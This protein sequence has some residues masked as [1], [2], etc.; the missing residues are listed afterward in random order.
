MES[1]VNYTAVGLFVVIL[2]AA[3]IGLGLWIGADISPKDY[4]RYDAFFNESVS[5]LNANAP[6]K[7]R[8]VTV[9][10]V[11]HI[12]LSPDNPQQV[13]VEMEIEA[14]IPITVATYA[15]LS[16]QGITGIAH[17]ELEGGD[18]LAAA[19]HAHE[20]QH[21]PII[22]TKPSL[23]TRID[24]AVSEVYSTLGVLSEDINMLLSDENRES[25]RMTLRNVAALTEVF[26][27]KST[28]LEKTFSDTANIIANVEVATE[29]LP[30]LMSGLEQ[31]VDEF[32]QTAGSVRGM[33]TGID[34]MVNDVHMELNRILRTS[35]PE[36]TV[37]IER[38]NTLAEEISLLSRKISTESNPLLFRPTQLKPGPGEE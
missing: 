27:G 36:M 15:T 19:L 14:H 1:K 20:G 30:T 28:D 35:G 12:Q 29:N 10:R 9:G 4:R 11:S 23:F 18:P 17:V 7:Y 22:P 2:S 26:S 13:L 38:L 31:A 16:V 37:L 5:G 3:L 6:V 32:N 24:D 34:E 25:V 21:H 8:G 33:T